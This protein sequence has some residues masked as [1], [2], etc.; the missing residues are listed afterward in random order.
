MRHSKTV[1]LMKIRTVMD[2]IEAVIGEMNC[3]FVYCERLGTKNEFITSNWKEIKK[4][5][6]PY[7]SLIIVQ[8]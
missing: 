3:S 8:K 7:F 5:S 1:V 4:R 2:T 6:I